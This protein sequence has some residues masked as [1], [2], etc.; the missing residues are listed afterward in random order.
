MFLTTAASGASVNYELRNNGEVRLEFDGSTFSISRLV[1]TGA[2]T[3]LSLEGT[4]PATGTMDVVATGSANLA[5]L[6]GFFPN[7]VSS[8]SATVS[9]RIV[10]ERAD[11]QVTG[12]ADIVAGR[13]RYRSFPHGLEAINGPITF[14]ANGIRA[15]RFNPDGSLAEQL[16]GVMGGGDVTIGGTIGL[17]GL[18]PDQFDLTAVGQN[19]RLR[20]PAGF[21]STVE[22]NLTL[23]GPITGPTLGGTVT[24]LRSAYQQELDSDIALLGWRRVAARRRAW[25][26][27]RTGPNRRSR[28]AS[29]SV[30]TRRAPWPSTLATPRCSDLPV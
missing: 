4:I 5:I 23:T 9:A 3:S 21:A 10:G 6:Q 8:G 30:S 14:D 7:L 20:Y 2:D 26:R 11:P 28:S 19:V 1:L 24:V 15:G 29:I 17:E 13:L 16:R 22:A 12:R 27:P 18:L 25:S